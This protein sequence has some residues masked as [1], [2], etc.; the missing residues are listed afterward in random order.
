[1][2]GVV[3]RVFRRGKKGEETEGRDRLRNGKERGN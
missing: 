3:S 1:M 2:L